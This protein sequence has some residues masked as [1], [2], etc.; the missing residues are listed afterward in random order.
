MDSTSDGTNHDSQNA[1]NNELDR[2]GPSSENEVQGH[3]IGQ[4]TANSNENIPPEGSTMPLNVEIQNHLVSQLTPVFDH[5]ENMIQNV[6]KM[7]TSFIGV[8]PM[9]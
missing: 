6:N 2:T 5:F 4:G 9:S 7:I 1:Q 3:E 8:A